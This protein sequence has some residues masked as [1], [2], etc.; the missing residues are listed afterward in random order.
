MRK[1]DFVTSCFFFRFAR[2]FSD[3][4]RLLYFRAI[5]KFITIMVTY[6]DSSVCII[7]KGNP[8]MYM[9]DIEGITVYTCDMCIPS[10]LF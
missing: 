8:R 6:S 10:K 4:E 9:Y 2:R 1:T 3:E 7:P 5:E